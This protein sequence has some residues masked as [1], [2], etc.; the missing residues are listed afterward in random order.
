MRNAVIYARYSSSG[1]R[2]ESIEGQLRDCHAFAAAEGLTV[3]EEYCDPA[4]TGRNDDRPRFQQM[5][6]DAEKKLFQYVIVWKLDRFS[7][8]RYDAAMYKNK[9]KNCGVKLLYAKEP[10][11]DDPTGILMESLMEGMAEY[12]SANLSQ[13]VKRGNYD[14]VLKGSA[15]GHQ[16]YGYD[17]GEDH[18]YHINATEAEIVRRVFREYAGGKPAREIIDDLTADG[19]RTRKGGKLTHNFVARLIGNEKYKGVYRYYE[20]TA[21]IERIVSDDLWEEAN[22]IMARHQHA[23]AAKADFLLSGRIICGECGQNFIGMSGK[24]HQGGTYY[25]YACSGR[26]KEKSCDMPHYGKEEI[27]SRVIEAVRRVL[28]ND[29][30]I[31]QVAE[32]CVRLQDNDKNPELDALIARRRTAETALNNLIAAV[33]ILQDPA[34]IQRIAERRAEI[35]DLDSAILREKKLDL[36]ISGDQ[37]KLFLRS[38]AAGDV[39]D[40]EYCRRL[41]NT[42]VNK[43]FV[44]KDRP[45]II[46]LNATG[47]KAK[48]ELKDV[49]PSSSFDTA[50]VPYVAKTNLFFIS[51]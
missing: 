41:I 28:D 10:I 27:E 19:I 13:N 33:E 49:P 23:P 44:Y 30:W 3:I 40:P 39:T 15:L 37:V 29:E 9:L 4:M 7:R 51:A 25:Y 21:P 18:C 8:N 47:K 38:F 22:I 48:V 43:I 35:A 6:K 42:F 16:C 34:I 36:K 2:D 11:P 26:R 24:G 14:S 32:D 1:Q 45:P 50:G 17:I 20:I 31:D 46:A 5:I 12:Y